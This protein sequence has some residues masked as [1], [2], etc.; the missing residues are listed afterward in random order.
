VAT[1]HLHHVEQPPQRPALRA[2][3]RD[4]VPRH[5]V[6]EIARA[7]AITGEDGA[8]AAAGESVGE[9]QRRE[10]VSA[11]AARRDHDG[12]A[13]GSPSPL[14]GRRRVSARNMP[15]PSASAQS[16]EPP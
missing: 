14:P 7:A 11:G 16:E 2:D 5:A 6:R 9:R 12:A 10:H 1:A 13:H 8:L 15:M 4:F 3:R